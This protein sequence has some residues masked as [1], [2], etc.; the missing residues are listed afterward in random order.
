MVTNPKYHDS[1]IFRLG[2]TTFEILTEPFHWRAVR[3]YRDFEWLY[4]ALTS[5][6]CGSF[7]PHL[8][9]KAFS[10]N[11]KEVIKFRQTSFQ[12]FLNWVAKHKSLSVSEDLEAFLKLGDAEFKTFREVAPDDKETRYVPPCDQKG[13]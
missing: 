12:D 7:V 11:E 3:R 4:K 5:K 8:P 6:F 13:I 10:S 1:G 9:N 2:Y